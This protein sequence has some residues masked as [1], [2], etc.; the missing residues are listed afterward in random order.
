VVSIVEYRVVQPVTSRRVWD[1]CLDA[2]RT[3]RLLHLVL[4]AHQSV[5]CPIERAVVMEIC[6]TTHIDTSIRLGGK[7]HGTDSNSIVVYLGNN[8][9]LPA[10]AS[11]VE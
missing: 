9:D 4:M 11:I 6:Q 10:R 7:V 3:D 8:L 5:P 1:Q 2:L